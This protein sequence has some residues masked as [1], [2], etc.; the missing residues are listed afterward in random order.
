MVNGEVPDNVLCAWGEPLILGEKR[1]RAVWSVTQGETSFILKKRPDSFDPNLESAMFRALSKQ[2]LPVTHPIVTRTGHQA[3]AS[4]EGLWSLY[5]FVEGYSVS[6]ATITASEAHELGSI[7][8][9]LHNALDSYTEGREQLSEFYVSG[10]LHD[11]P[12]GII[13]RDFHPGNIIF[14]AGSVRAIVDF[15]LI[16]RG[17]RA[18][19]LA[20]LGASLLASSWQNTSLHERF[21]PVFADIVGGYHG[22]RLLRSDE[23]ST[24]SVLLEEVENMFVK[25]GKDTDN[26]YMESSAREVLLWFV[27]QRVAITEALGRAIGV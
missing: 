6:L 2:E 17:P 9:Q 14:S 13:H 26:K 3:H 20:Y 23:I 18:F 16:C 5:P 15:D 27:Q 7:L 4:H 8:A 22:K 10:Q 21:I 12:Q 25:L 24:I 11:C 19:D 1:G